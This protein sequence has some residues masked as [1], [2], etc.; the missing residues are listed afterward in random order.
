MPPVGF[1]PTVSVLERTK[2]VHTVDRAATVISQCYIIRAMKLRTIGWTVMRKEMHT[3]SGKVT[4][5]T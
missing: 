1:E 4:L 2:T 5:E 3:G